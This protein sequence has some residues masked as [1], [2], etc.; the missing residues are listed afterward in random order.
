MKEFRGAEALRYARETGIDFDV[1]EDFLM[2]AEEAI[3]GRRTSMADVDEVIEEQTGSSY[4]PAEIISGTGVFDFLINRYGDGWIYV[5]LEGDDPEAE[6]TVTLRMYRR[7][8]LEPEPI[9]ASDVKYLLVRYGRVRLGRTGFPREADLNLLF[10]AALRLSGK[11]ILVSL[12]DSDPPSASRTA[13][14]GRKRFAVPA[15]LEVS[16]EK[17]MCE[18]CRHAR[19][20][21]SLSLHR[22]CARRLKRVLA[23]PT[24]RR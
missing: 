18:M 1:D 3:S 10:Q 9:S 19:G 22:E 6:E 13:S 21:T 5:P 11:G 7:L 17:V 20:T 2:E 8:L 24:K 4:D 16:L 15:D 14:Y 23:E 12:I